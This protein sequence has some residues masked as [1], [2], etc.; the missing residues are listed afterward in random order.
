MTVV[1]RIGHKIFYFHFLP[2]LFL[3]LFLF[4]GNQVLWG[5]SYLRAQAW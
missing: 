5:T 3:F 1:L 4:E 2:G